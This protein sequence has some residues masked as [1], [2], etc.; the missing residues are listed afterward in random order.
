MT[1]IPVVL[2]VNS[3]LQQFHDNS[4]HYGHGTCYKAMARHY[5]WG[6][7]S[8]DLNQWISRCSTCAKRSKRK[9]LRCSI[10]N[11]TNCCGPVERGLGLTFYKYLTLSLTH[12]TY[13]KYYTFLMILE[14]VP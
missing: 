7:M 10:V 9:W 6:T 14:F 2:Q 8:R 12:M 4:D 11:C 1:V 5:Y 3:I 13:L